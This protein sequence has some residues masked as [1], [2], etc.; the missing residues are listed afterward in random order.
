M[1]LEYFTHVA[2][3]RGPSYPARI[4]Q[5]KG[6][7]YL[8]ELAKFGEAS[9][10]SCTLWLK[11]GQIVN[12]ME[13]QI[14]RRI[15][16]LVALG[17]ISK[18]YCQDI[19]YYLI[20][21]CHKL[22]I[23]LEILNDEREEAMTCSEILAMVPKKVKKTIF[24]PV[25]VEEHTD[26]DGPPTYF[27]TDVKKAQRIYAEGERLFKRN[28]TLRDAVMNLNLDLGAPGNHWRYR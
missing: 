18:E 22:N 4:F 14:F 19:R 26:P 16:R 17:P 3:N 5:Y 7:P 11:G 24:G 8:A 15:E 21:R 27:M 1:N 2:P 28:D 10:Y 25:D 13:G 23:T 12:V 9:H 6:V 20:R